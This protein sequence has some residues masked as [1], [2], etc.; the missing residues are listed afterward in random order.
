MVFR[1]GLSTPLLTE[2]GGRLGWGCIGGLG[3]MSGLV[4]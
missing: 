2:L 3:C 4:D 1:N